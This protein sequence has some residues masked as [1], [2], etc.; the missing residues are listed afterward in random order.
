[1]QSDEL[2]WYEP[3]LILIPLANPP[4]KADRFSESDPASAGTRDGQPCWGNE[5]EHASAAAAWSVRRASRLKPD[6]TR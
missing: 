1:M 6:R 2:V 4:A 5:Q 3:S